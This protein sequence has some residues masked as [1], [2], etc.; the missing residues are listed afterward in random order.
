M[1]HE[2]P[3]RTL[4]G[5]ASKVFGTAIVIG[6]NTTGI[7][8]LLGSIA[9]AGA[10][11]TRGAFGL[12]GSGAGVLLIIVSFLIGF[13]LIETGERIAPHADS[14]EPP[15]TATSSARADEDLRWVT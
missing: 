10:L 8:I 3:A 6:G 12:I 13:I 1:K 7:V 15:R 2:H 14:N 5:V 9:R 11:A 4:L